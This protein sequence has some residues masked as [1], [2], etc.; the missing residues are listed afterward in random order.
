M[1]KKLKKLAALMLCTAMT[2]MMC[3]IVS[4]AAG[5][6]LRFSDPSTTVGATVEITA[7]LSSDESL[8]KASATLTYDTTALKFISGDNATASNG[9]IDLEGSGSGDTEIN[10]TLK[11]QALSEGTTT[12]NISKVSASSSSG[13]S[14]DV[15]EGSS[16]VTIGE[17]DPSLITDDE[18]SSEGTTGGGGEIQIDGQTYTVVTDIPEVLIPDG[19]VT[20]DMS[21]NGNT[22]AATKQE[23]GKVYAIYLQNADG[24]EDFWLYDPDK[25]SFSPF[26]QVSISSDRYIVLLSQ[27]KTK[28]LPDTLQKTTMTVEGK[29]FPAWQ[30]T[31][32][33]SY[34]VV[35]A[36][37]SDG[38]EGFYQYDTVDE[39]YQRYTPESKD[40]EEDTTKLG[41]LLNKLRTNLDK[42]ILV[43]WGIFLVML[44]ILIILATKLRHRNLELDDLYEEYD[45]DDEPEPVKES[46]KEKKARK[47]AEKEA[48]K[49][50]KSKKKSEDDF[51]DF[52]DEDDEYDDLDDDYE[53]EP[54]E[55]DDYD[56]Y[57]EYEEEPFTEYDPA[58]YEDDSDIDDLDEILNAR[59]RVKK[60]TPR[61]SNM[62]SVGPNR[63][64]RRVGHSEADDTFKMDLIDLD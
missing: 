7:K 22:Y 28:E 62:A 42:V 35:Y 50:K 17:G 8:S 61:K 27:D 5:T 36:L 14:L 55:E 24:E 19:F 20:A 26:E 37:N 51:Y 9:Q 63:D 1:M 58:D 53:E 43:A 31:D 2:F 60:K 54:Y 6:Q 40:K 4:S 13:G 21:Y 49:S 56:E 44:L 30:N 11:F 32:A 16:T 45:I 3:G 48:K 12:V 29:E 38:E 47:K 46:K 25:D 64:L 41:G 39:T 23:N 34:Y 15:V 18:E 10:W 33:S 59:V 52:D 57:D